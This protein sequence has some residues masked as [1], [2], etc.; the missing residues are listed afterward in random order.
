MFSVRKE[1]WEEEKSYSLGFSFHNNDVIWFDWSLP[2]AWRWRIIFDIFTKS[3]FSIVVMARSVSEFDIV[4][5]NPEQRIVL[6]R[7]SELHVLSYS[8]DFRRRGHVHS[9]TSG[10]RILENIFFF[11]KIFKKKSTTVLGT[12]SEPNGPLIKKSSSTR[13]G[14][15]N[16][17]VRYSQVHKRMILFFLLFYHFYGSFSVLIGDELAFLCDLDQAAPGR[18]FKRKS[19]FSPFF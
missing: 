3:S 15:I 18:F 16:R 2:F 9:S 1:I 19:T 14:A 12:W 4:G 7:F 17:A 10:R 5:T 11:Q 8:I 13:S 6:L